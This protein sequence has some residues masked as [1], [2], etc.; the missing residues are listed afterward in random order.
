MKSQ[1]LNLAPFSAVLVSPIR[2]FIPQ[3]AIFESHFLIS[4]QTPL[5]SNINTLDSRINILMLLLIWTYYFVFFWFYLATFQ[6]HL[7]FIVISCK[8]NVAIST[9]HLYISCSSFICNY[10]SS[11]DFYCNAI[12]ETFLA[13]SIRKLCVMTC[14]SMVWIQYP[15]NQ[16]YVIRLEYTE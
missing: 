2:T 3:I 8:E 5:Q 15:I 13:T 12:E 10:T 7:L 16:W 9:R 4:P 6:N 11:K 1:H 14:K